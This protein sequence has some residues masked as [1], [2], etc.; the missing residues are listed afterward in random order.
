ML[1]RAENIP[2][3]ILGYPREKLRDDRYEMIDTRFFFLSSLI[4]RS[5]VRS[6]V[7]FTRVVV[8]PSKN[9]V[10]LYDSWFVFFISFFFLLSRIPALR[11]GLI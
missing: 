3:N 10:I 1:Q 2:S 11:C 8:N 7:G 6:F 9:F 4:S 5:F